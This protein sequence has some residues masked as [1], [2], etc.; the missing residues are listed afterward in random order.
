MEPS[1]PQ[2]NGS[3]LPPAVIE[4]LVDQ[5][6]QEIEVRSREIELEAQKD[7]HGFE[8]AQITIDSQLKDRESERQHF[9]RTQK[10]ALMFLGI[11]ATLFFAF[12]GY[13]LHTNKDQIVMEII[14]AI[15]FFLAG[16]AGGYGL[17]TS[18]KKPEDNN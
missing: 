15:G 17:A 9:R 13:A 3:Q 2:R 11:V 7:Q 16:G 1:Q 6:S 18:R 4:K 14:K 12:L 5:K 10:A 8:Y